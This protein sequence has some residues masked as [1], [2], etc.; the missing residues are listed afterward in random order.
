MELYSCACSFVYLFIYLFINSLHDLLEVVGYRE[1]IVSLISLSK[2]LCLYVRSH[3]LYL[4][5]LLHRKS[6]VLCPLFTGC[7]IGIISMYGSY[8]CIMYA[9]PGDG[10]VIHVKRQRSLPFLA[11][12]VFS[13]VFLA[14]NW[15][16]WAISWFTQSGRTLRGVVFLLH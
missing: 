14:Q 8:L 16:F 10:D 15:P 5:Y 3:L 9:V 4:R 6:S 11:Y 1:L 7:R 12:S 2:V 13:S